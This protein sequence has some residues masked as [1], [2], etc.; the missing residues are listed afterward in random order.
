MRVIIQKVHSASV[1]IDQHVYASINTGLLCF[2]GFCDDD[3]KSDF[4][5]AINKIL[6]LKLF[7]NQSSIQDINGEVL[8]VSQFTLFASI[9]KGNK[10]SWSRAANP[11]LASQMYDKFVS[12]CKTK[13]KNNIKTGVFGSDMNIKSINNG[14]VTLIVDT[15]KKE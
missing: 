3:E 2:V 10:P 9:K 14:P 4:E 13:L 15:K 7:Q 12:I 5:W 6:N 11:D 8:I 1:V